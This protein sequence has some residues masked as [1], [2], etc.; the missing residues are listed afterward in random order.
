MNKARKFPMFVAA[1]ALA[2][3]LASAASADTLRIGYAPSVWDPSDF[4]GMMGSGIEDG[5]KAHGIDYEFLIRAPANHVAHEE[6]LAIVENLIA[7]GVDYIIVNPTDP[8][9]QRVVYEKV[10]ESGIPLIVGNYSVPFPDDW[11]FQPLMFTGYSHADAGVVLA[12][13]LH[14]KYGEGTEIAVIHGSP[15]FITEARAPKDL[16]DE[17]GM[18]FIYEEFADFDRVKAYD[19]MERIIV[20]H[21]DVKVVVATSSAM[22]IGAVEAAAANGVEGQYDIYGAGGTFEELRSIEDG[23]LT[24]AWIRDPVAMG[25]A[26]ADAIKARMEGRDGD[27]PPIFKSP[28]YLIDSVEKI[29]DHVNPVIYEAEGLEFPRPTS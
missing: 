5:L 17:L 18:S 19:A 14:D 11:G 1:S 10:I 25:R 2:I 4:H 7:E 6:Q 24:G 15:G 3:G 22:A 29:N 27:I 23:V 8:L 20:T 12:N 21:P 16:Y 9:L 26:V 28:I 13:Y